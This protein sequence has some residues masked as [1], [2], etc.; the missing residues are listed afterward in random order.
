MD[1]RPANPLDTL[2]SVFVY[3]PIGFLLDARQLVPQ[4]TTRGRQQ[5]ELLKVAAKFAVAKGKLDAEHKLRSARRPVPPNAAAES[6][7]AQASEPSPP[8]RSRPTPAGRPAAKRAARPA[9]KGSNSP[10]RPP[11]A[12]YDTLSATQILPRLPALSRRDLA[13]VEHYER[14]HRGRRTILGRIEQLR[15]AEG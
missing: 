9:A 7:A 10:A 11:I 12:S 15:A 8:A 5:V 14:T 4:L 6:P 1:E 2:L 13:V 3:A